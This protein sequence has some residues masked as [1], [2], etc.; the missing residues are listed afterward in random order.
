MADNLDAITNKTLA[1][2]VYAGFGD[3]AKTF[4]TMD[5]YRKRFPVYY[6]SVKCKLLYD[7]LK[8]LGYE[9]STEEE[10]MLNG[11]HAAFRAWEQFS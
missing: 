1:S 10:A 4:C 6:M 5:T 7:W 11:T 9:P 2:L 3:D 8:R